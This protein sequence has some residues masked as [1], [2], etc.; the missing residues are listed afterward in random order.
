[1]GLKCRFPWFRLP[2]TPTAG[3]SRLLSGKSQLL[4]LSPHFLTQLGVSAS[5][6]EGWAPV[7]L[8]PAH[9]GENHGP[10]EA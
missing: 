6:G 10:S 7:L 3:L 8:C 4:G 9:C 2:D 5:Q 1:M